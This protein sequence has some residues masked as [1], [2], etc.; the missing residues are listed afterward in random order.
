MSN[1]SREKRFNSGCVNPL[2]PSMQFKP[3]VGNVWSV[4]IGD[5]SRP[6][7]QTRQS[8]RLVWIGTPEGDNN[9]TKQSR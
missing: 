2:H 9:F 4:R 6:V 5:H 8:R 1:V 7:A 3:L